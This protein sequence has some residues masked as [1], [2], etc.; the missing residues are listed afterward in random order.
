MGKL[1][2][3]K[4]PSTVSLDGIRMTESER[5]AARA[6]LEQGARIACFILGVAAAV[7]AVARGVGLRLQALARVKSMN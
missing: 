7:S 6:A 5:A 1:V 2:R 3:R 4:S